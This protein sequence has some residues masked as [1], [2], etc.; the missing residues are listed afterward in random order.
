MNKPDDIGLPNRHTGQKKFYWGSVLSI[1]LRRIERR[2]EKVESRTTKT[3][4]EG[5]LPP[6][7]PSSLS[8]RLSEPWAW[9]MAFAFEKLIVYQKS[10][11]FADQ[12]C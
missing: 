3:A 5:Y 9:F 1:R 10:I 11:Y 8:F 7:L 6:S 2:G 12:V 4:F